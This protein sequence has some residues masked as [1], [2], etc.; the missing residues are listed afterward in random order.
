MTI[1]GDR[2]RYKSAFSWTTRSDPGVS[3]GEELKNVQRIT[4]FE[5][6]HRVGRK[7]RK[8]KI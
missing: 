6:T 7:N 5:K 2:T 1:A 4:S 8:K 3:S